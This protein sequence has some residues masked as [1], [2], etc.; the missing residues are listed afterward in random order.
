MGGTVASP[1]PSFQLSCIFLPGAALAEAC[2]GTP[3]A[4]ECIAAAFVTPA[5]TKAAAG[6]E[7]EAPYKGAAAALRSYRSAKIRVAAR[8]TAVSELEHRHAKMFEAMLAAPTETK[9]ELLREKMEGLR[10]AL[11]EARD[12]I[13]D[14]K[15]SLKRS[16]RI[17]LVALSKARSRLPGHISAIAGKPDNFPPPEPFVVPD[18]LQGDSPR[19]SPSASPSPEPEVDLLKLAGKK[20]RRSATSSPGPAV[21]SPSPLSA[22]GKTPAELAAAAKARALASLSD[23]MRAALAALERKRA[24]NEASLFSK[25]PRRAREV[26]RAFRTLRAQVRKTAVAELASEDRATLAA[27]RAEAAKTQAL[28][29]VK[30]STRQL[31]ARQLRKLKADV[32]AA[33][34][35]ARQQRA[36]RQYVLRSKVDAEIVAALVAAKKWSSLRGGKQAAAAK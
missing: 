5:V 9:R 2:R 13:V 25:L 17:A 6:R 11:L 23:G 4:A 26:L 10:E 24:E 30:L 14:A 27:H 12:S 21:P 19:R 20:R 3:S 7:P 8:K 35:S 31:R 34:H 33:L 36:V 1:H 15:A 22:A 28:E 32:R 29:E 18:W 16:R